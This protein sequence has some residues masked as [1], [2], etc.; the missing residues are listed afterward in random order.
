MLGDGLQNTCKTTTGGRLSKNM[1]HFSWGKAFAAGGRNT[2]AGGGLSKTGNT[3][4]G[5]G[6]LKHMQPYNWG[7]ACKTQATLQL[8]DGFCCGRACKKH[9][10]AIPGEGRPMVRR[11]RTTQRKLSHLHSGR[12]SFEFH[13]AQLLGNG[14]PSVI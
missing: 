13:R 11:L 12:L 6:L 7:K 1:Q 8:G 4:A 9:G 5:G 2:I 14:S 10:R 3:T